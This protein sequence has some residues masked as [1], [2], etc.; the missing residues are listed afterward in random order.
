MIIFHAFYLIY[1]S[2]NSH[3]K[4]IL[5]HIAKFVAGIVS[6]GGGFSLGREGPSVYL[7]SEKNLLSLR[8]MFCLFS[9]ERRIRSRGTLLCMI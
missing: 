4:S 3:K 8:F 6:I 1:P 2:L 9:T 5:F 7:M